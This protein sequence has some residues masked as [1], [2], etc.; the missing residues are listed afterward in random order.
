MQSIILHK[1]LFRWMRGSSTRMTIENNLGSYFFMCFLR[2]SMVRCHA[3]LV[4][5]SWKLPRSSQ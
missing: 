5:A 3:S 1:K 2:K 4:L